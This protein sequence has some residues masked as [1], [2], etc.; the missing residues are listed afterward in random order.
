MVYIGQASI[1]SYISTRAIE[2]SYYGLEIC[3]SEIAI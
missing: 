1:K 2:S 3:C